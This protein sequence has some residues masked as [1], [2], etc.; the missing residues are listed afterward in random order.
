MS[1]SGAPKEIASSNSSKNEMSDVILELSETNEFQHEKL[2]MS[3]SLNQSYYCKCLCFIMTLKNKPKTG[4]KFFTF[5]W[6]LMPLE[7]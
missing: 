3:S 7:C 6:C 4:L 1:L 5:T 2:L